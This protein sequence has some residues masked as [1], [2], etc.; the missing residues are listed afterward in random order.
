MTH[1]ISVDYLRWIVLLPLFG[2]ML[3]GIPGIL[4]QRRFGKKAISLIAC[5]PVVIAFVLAVR[6][7]VH[8]L[9]LDPEQRFLL[10]R[11][12]TWFDIGGARADIAFLADPLS[13]VMLLVVTGVGGVIHI[14]ATGYMHDEESYWRFFAW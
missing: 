9:S 2:A 3:N 4:I 13:A 14:Y 8:L 12:W 1:P 10:D 5:T 7:L 6:V 11:L